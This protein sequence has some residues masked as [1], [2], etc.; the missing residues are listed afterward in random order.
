MKQ[1][2]FGVL[3]LLA[4]SACGGLRGHSVGQNESRA[5]L[6]ADELVE[7]SDWSGHSLSLIHI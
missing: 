7:L 1:T 6:I 5:R 4:T 3:M 2:C